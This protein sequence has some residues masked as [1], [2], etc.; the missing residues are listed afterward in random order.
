MQ[1]A[2][3]GMRRRVFR[4]E[5]VSDSLNCRGR[6]IPTRCLRDTRGRCRDRRCDLCAKPKR[7]K[8]RPAFD[9]WVREVRHAKRPA[10][11]KKRNQKKP[12]R[13]VTLIVIIHA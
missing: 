4:C 7:P 13:T 5:M 1:N 2:V 12:A 3:K 11:S 6:R 9:R 8:W 10:S